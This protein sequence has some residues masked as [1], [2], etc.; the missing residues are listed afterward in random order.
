MSEE[1]GV[2]LVVEDDLNSL[3]LMIDLLTAEGYTVHTQVNGLAAVDDALNLRPDLILLDVM[4]PGLNG[5]EICQRLKASPIAAD[6]PVI[7]LS[8]LTDVSEK[9]KAFRAGGADYVSK[10]FPPEEVLMRIKTHLSLYRQRKQID[11]LRAQQV[12]SLEQI[13]QLQNEVLRVVS[14]DLKVPLSVI[15]SSA[16]MLREDV[17]EQPTPEPRLLEYARM[18]EQSV[19]KM[20][21]LIVDLLDAIRLEST[22]RFD[23]EPIALG[24]YLR[25]TLDE[26]QHAAAAKGLTLTLQAPTPDI[27]VNISPERM[28]QALQNLISNAVKYTPSGGTVT[29]SAAQQ[30]STLRIRVQDTGLGIPAIDIPNLFEKFYRVQRPEHQAQSGTGLGLAIVKT[31]VEQHGGTIEV[32]SVL[33]EGSTFTVILPLKDQADDA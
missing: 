21:G 24:D 27:T 30:D 6:I 11:S 15:K 32:E 23:R 26:H 29:L 20:T 8:A 3:Q 18:I 33:E 5:F 14:H 13:T 12:G 7:F 9:I 10:P 22:P 31:V 1:M 25:Q 19:N 2:L 17:L 4:L 28:W 16:Q